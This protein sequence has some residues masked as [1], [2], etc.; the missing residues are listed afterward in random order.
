MWVT[1][2]GAVDGGLRCFSVV[3]ILARSCY[4]TRQVEA[5]HKAPAR[6]AAGGAD[7]RRPS[8]KPREEGDIERGVVM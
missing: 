6:A 2:L 4:R 8:P 7:R 1:G 3:G 5:A